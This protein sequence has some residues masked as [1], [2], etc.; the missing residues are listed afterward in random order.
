MLWSDLKPENFEFL[1]NVIG[2][3]LRDLEK[4]TNTF[5]FR[6]TELARTQQG[7]K[8]V[9]WPEPSPEAGKTFSPTDQSISGFN[10]SPP[11]GAYFD[12]TGK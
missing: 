11:S 10:G 9:H 3:T 6:V 8:D 12:P 1:S 5:L 4:L 7:F 2:A